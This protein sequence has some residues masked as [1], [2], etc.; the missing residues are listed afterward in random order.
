[1]YLIDGAALG[2]CLA[3]TL[4]AYALVWVPLAKQHRAIVQQ[5]VQL[6]A[7]RQKCSQLNSS[8]LTLQSQSLTIEKAIKD[9]HV[10]LEPADRINQR[11]ADLTNLLSQYG[12]EIDD[13]QT[14]Q[15]IMGS[16]CD[17]VPIAISGKG[18]YTA[19][20]TFFHEMYRSLPDMAV[21]HFDLFGDPDPTD[22]W[23][24]F[25]YD[26]FWFAEPSATSVTERP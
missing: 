20:A 19:C 9:S 10:Q 16:M 14:G 13:I 1:M 22:P 18:R 5:D 24:Q 3:A 25:K 2:L 8:M 26:L 4:G 12:L 15:I 21:A 23:S 11:I 17:L 6:G 7:Q